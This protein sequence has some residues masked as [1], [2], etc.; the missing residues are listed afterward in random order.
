MAVPRTP[1]RTHV[2]PQPADFFFNLRDTTL[3][4]FAKAPGIDWVAHLGHLTTMRVTRILGRRNPER[5]IGVYRL[6][7]EPWQGT[8]M[9]EIC[10]HPLVAAHLFITEQIL[11]GDVMVLLGDDRIV[12]GRTKPLD[13]SCDLTRQLG[14]RQ[15]RI[16]LSTNFDLAVRKI[17]SGNSGR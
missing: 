15:A 8:D 9:P 7:L 3:S 14:V 11:L 2:T 6:N 17:G 5:E 13:R 10:L 1:W 12:R 4:A 16:T